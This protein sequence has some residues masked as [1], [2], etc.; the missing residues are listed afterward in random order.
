VISW[1]DLIAF[2][3]ERD[4]EAEQLNAFYRRCLEFNKPPEEVK[5]RFQRDAEARAR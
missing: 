1:E 4:P 5:P 2:L 3:A